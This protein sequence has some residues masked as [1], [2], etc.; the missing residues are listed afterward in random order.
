M[1]VFYVLYASFIL[2]EII[3]VMHLKSIL[4]YFVALCLFLLG[5]TDLWKRLKAEHLQ[6]KKQKALIEANRDLE[7]K[8]EVQHLE[9]DSLQQRW[10]NPIPYFQTI[11]VRDDEVQG[12]KKKKFKVRIETN[13]HVE[14]ASDS[15]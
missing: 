15:H 5:N 10:E 9:F 14:H 2:I 3:I 12:L 7:A 6:E 8:F 11:H 13:R 4:L 1:L